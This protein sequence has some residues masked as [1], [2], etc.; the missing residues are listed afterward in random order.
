M[1]DHTIIIGIAGGTGSG[2][3]TLIHSIKS[4]FRDEVAILSHDFYY[5]KHDDMSYEERA[6]LNYDH[7]DA[8]ETDL[9]I[10]Q[11]RDLKAGKSV[12][13][14]VYDFVIHNRVQ[15][16]VVIHPARV[17]IVEGILIFEN[18]DLLAEFDIKVYV[19]TDADV[20]IIR[21]IQRDVRDRGRNMESVIEQYLTTVKPMHE[22]FVEPSKKNA[23]IIIPE[24]GYNKVALQMLHDRIKNLLIQNQGGHLN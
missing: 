18:K 15:D 5:K 7:P 8:F 14:P 17:I 22:V 16:T 13:R 24:G 4:V 9:L 21:R 12:N 6:L 2:K 10:S 3:S 1:T 20:R 11:I 19:D 23:D